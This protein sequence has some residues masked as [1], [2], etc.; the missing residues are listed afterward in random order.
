MHAHT[1]THTH[2]HTHISPHINRS[3][4]T[5]ENF[6]GIASTQNDQPLEQHHTSDRSNEKS[7]KANSGYT[8][9]EPAL[10]GISKPGKTGYEISGFDSRVPGGPGMSPRGVKFDM[11]APKPENKTGKRLTDDDR[12]WHVC[13]RVCFAYVCLCV[14]VYVCVCAYNVLSDHDCEWL[15]CVCVCMCV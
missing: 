3:E 5:R 4:G 1:H 2:T 15:V 10:T 7:T 14:C 12:E 8:S 13:V 6:P 11:E 9:I